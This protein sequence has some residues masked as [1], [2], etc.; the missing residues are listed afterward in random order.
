MSSWRKAT[1]DKGGSKF[2]CRYATRVNLVRGVPWTEIHGYVRCLATRGANQAES[3]T[4][5]S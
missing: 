5:T 4:V 2:K 3:R 1:K